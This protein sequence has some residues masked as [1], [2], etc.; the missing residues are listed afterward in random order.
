[1]SLQGEDHR[2]G[3]FP[4]MGVLSHITASFTAST[5]H[6]TSRVY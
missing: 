5:G 3:M 6:H 1:V 4:G 2:G